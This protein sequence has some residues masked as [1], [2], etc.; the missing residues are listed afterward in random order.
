MSYYRERVREL[1]TRDRLSFSYRRLNSLYSYEQ[2]VLDGEKIHVVERTHGS[3]TFLTEKA[4][5]QRIREERR[6]ISGD[7]LADGRIAMTRRD[8]LQRLL[9]YK[10]SRHVFPAGTSIPLVSIGAVASVS[11]E[12]IF[13]DRYGLLA[14]PVAGHP[15]TRPQSGRQ[16]TGDLTNT[17]QALPLNG[18]VT[19]LKRAL[20]LESIGTFNRSDMYNRRLKESLELAN[21]QRLSGQWSYK[22]RWLSGFN[23]IVDAQTGTRLTQKVINQR[24]MAWYFTGDWTR[25]TEYVNTPQVTIT[26][27]GECHALPV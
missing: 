4:Y 24:L 18:S 25:Y 6:G 7:P 8:E 17:L 13:D 1:L 26:N 19:G 3:I 21:S 5:K 27:V 12:L 9:G 23:N 20:C 15:H 10:Y 11:Y 2:S 16:C 14:T 22:N